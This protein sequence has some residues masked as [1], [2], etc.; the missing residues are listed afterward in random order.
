MT[1][2]CPKLSILVPAYNVGPYIDDFL[3]S[4]AQQI[5]A[6]ST[7]EPLEIIFL[8]D[9][10][11][12]DT[13]NKIKQHYRVSRTARILE[14]PENRGVSN[15]R[16][17]LL[18]HAQGEYVWFID[19]DDI[20]EDGAI[21]NVMAIV[22][23]YAPDLI[24]SDFIVRDET[25]TRNSQPVTRA[26]S[27]HRGKEGL[28]KESKD[29]ILADM[30][31]IDK[32]YVWNKIFRRN[33]VTQSEIRFPDW[34]CYED[35]PFPMQI[36]A[37]SNR[38]F[39]SHSALITYRRRQGSILKTTDIGK[40]DDLV[41]SLTAIRNRLAPH[42]S[43]ANNLKLALQYCAARNYLGLIDSTYRLDESYA[44]GKIRLLSDLLNGGTAGKLIMDLV[45]SLKFQRALEI[46]KLRHKKNVRL[47]LDKAIS[48]A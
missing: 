15:A 30:L 48:A 23:R 44:L 25:R 2:N 42:L 19:P 13:L 11:T 36:A 7:S 46:L 29:S 45:F 40:I 24:I 12:D 39:Y 28:L 10:S 1:N 43:R 21:E 17:V 4:L 47:L 38:V 22:E 20:M 16:N 32:M 3:S 9:C 8:D 26:R 27:G 37:N 35:M 14:L 6:T 18:S 33:I 31:Y 5:D 34:Q 41:A